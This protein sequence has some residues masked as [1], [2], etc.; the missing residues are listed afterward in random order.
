VTQP[1]LN[2][3]ALAAAHKAAIDAWFPG[4]KTR[5]ECTEA[6]I[7]AYLSADPDRAARDAVVKATV[8]WADACAKFTNVWNTPGASAR[9]IGKL[10]EAASAKLSA[11]VATLPREKE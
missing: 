11:A 9:T 7:R 10:A 3:A 6:A 5:A 1:K 4:N 2:E 8:K